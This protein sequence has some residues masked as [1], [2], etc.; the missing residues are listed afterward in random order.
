MNTIT[1]IHTVY[2]EIGLDTLLNRRMRADMIQT[3]KILK[4][5]DN[6][7]PSVWFRTVENNNSIQTRRSAYPLNLLHQRSNL[8]IR[9]NFFSVR[10]A[11]PWNSLP[12]SVKSA[13]KIEQFKKLYDDYSSLS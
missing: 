10:V 3:F 4:G 9:R 8:E 5:V 7:D 12:K 13:E 6:V 11:E 2:I 1:F